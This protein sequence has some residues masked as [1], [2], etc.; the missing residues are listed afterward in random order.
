MRLAADSDGS[1]SAPPQKRSSRRLA[2][3]AP[4]AAESEPGS[5]ANE[6][7]RPKRRK[8][9][10]RRQA[11][12]RPARQAPEP[13]TASDTPSESSRPVVRRSSQLRRQVAAPAPAAVK[14]YRSARQQPARQLPEPETPS[15]TPV[16]DD[17]SPV[18]RRRS[19]RRL[20]QRTHEPAAAGQ[21]AGPA[22]LPAEAHSVSVGPAEVPAEP[23]DDSDA[24][25]PARRAAAARTTAVAGRGMLLRP[26]RSLPGYAF[27]GLARACLQLLLSA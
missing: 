24:A 16:S 4:D 23:S 6:Q 3:Q 2:R 15:D 8:G 17:N 1:A 20:S 22:S 7:A 27:P 12:Q 9:K 13:W 21:D 11:K 5:A 18:V 19:S 14:R 10:Q 26:E 25:R